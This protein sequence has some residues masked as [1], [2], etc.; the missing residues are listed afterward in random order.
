M[1]VSII[2]ADELRKKNNEEGLVLEG[3]GGD[4]S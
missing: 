2:S 1:S 3:C 4:P